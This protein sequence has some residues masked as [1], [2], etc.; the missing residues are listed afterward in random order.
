MGGNTPHFTRQFNKERLK[1]ELKKSQKNY[2]ISTVFCKDIHPHTLN[3]PQG[4]ATA[5][6]IDSSF[7]AEMGYAAALEDK[8]NAQA[9][10]IIELEA[11]V[12]GKTVLTDATNYVAGAVAIGINKELNDTKAIM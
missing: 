2:E 3:I 6:T 1:L 12:D 5:T 7:T 8:E 10:R 9:E 4:E 11:R